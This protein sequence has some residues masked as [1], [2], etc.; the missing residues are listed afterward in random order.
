MKKKNIKKININILPKR[1]YEIV[2]GANFLTPCEF[3]NLTR[4][5]GKSLIVT[6]E[7]VYKFF[8]ALID[9]SGIE[10]IILKPGEDEKKLSNVEKICRKALAVGLDRTS[11]LIAVGGGVTGDIAGFAASIYMRGIN[12]VQIPT[13]LLAMVDSSVGGKTGVDLPEGKNLIGTFWQPSKVLTDIFFLKTLPQREIK[14][15]LAEIIKYGVI[16]DEKFFSLL[17]N[18]T[19]KIKKVE[20]NFFLNI[21]EKSCKLKACVVQKDEK[22]NGLR[23]ILNYGHSFGHAIEKCCSYSL[24]SHGE[25]VAIGM[26]IAAKFAVLSS[27]MSKDDEIRQNSLLDALNLPNAAPVCAEDIFDAMSS[28]KKTKKGKIRIVAPEKI[29]K[30]KLIELKDK[31]I[32]LDAIKFYCKR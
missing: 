18:N 32:A 30:V 2:L 21:I 3:R 23:A 28:D 13:T 1:K 19:E 14:C 12:F 7:N 24:L 26:R 29:G 20:Q 15:G 22:E 16:L 25:A 27:L 31:K 6:D 10:K 9:D 8:S 5:A 17:E 4:N 11:L